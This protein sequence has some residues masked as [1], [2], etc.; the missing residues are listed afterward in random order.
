MPSIRI[1]CLCGRSVLVPPHL[2][3]VAKKCPACLRL[4]KAPRLDADGWVVEVCC[5]T[6]QQTVQIPPMRSQRI[7]LCPDGHIVRIPILVPDDDLPPTDSH[8]PD[9]PPPS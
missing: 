5:P 7:V 4:V 6:C 2:H 1:W 3:G 8:P 9:T